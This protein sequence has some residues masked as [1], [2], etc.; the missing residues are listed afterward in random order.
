MSPGSPK[1]P[2]RAPTLADV[3][4]VA[5]VS[6]V[7]ASAVLNGS[8][9]SSR[10]SA[11][12]RARILEAAAK[13]DYRVNA[14]ARALARQRMHTIGVAVVVRGGDL[15]HY[16]LE[17]FNGVLARAAKEN[18]NATVFTL[19]NWDDDTARLSSFC[20]GRI[21]GMIL[22]GPLFPTERAKELPPH[23]PFV[24]LHA[25]H[26][27]P[28]VVNIESDEETGAYNMVR[29]L[30]DRGHRRILHL[31]GGA[32]LLG[33]QRRLRGYQRALIDCGVMPD[34]NLVAEA[35]FNMSDGRRAT[36]EWLARSVRQP[37]PDAVFCVN[38]RVALGCMEVMAERGFKVPGD[39][40]IAGFDD[41]L[42]ARTSLPQLTTVRQNLRD[43]GSAAVE[44]LLTHVEHRRN[45]ELPVTWGPIVFPTELVLRS[46]V[47]A[48]PARARRIAA[49][50]AAPA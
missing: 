22:V 46:S 30:I 5:G 15:D 45:P 1:K 11:K 38:D 8:R 43:M 10:I 40:S 28:G 39:I 35:G 41:S 32:G 4:R 31:S 44:S 25:N 50:P 42:A 20:D 21:D 26:P 12:T 48:P 29:H 6:A 2:L 36:R 34:D 47:A 3:G 37:L 33:A 7:A 18:Q 14:A 19:H 17:V 16:F 27:L 13:L 9:T 24:S 23:T 49:L